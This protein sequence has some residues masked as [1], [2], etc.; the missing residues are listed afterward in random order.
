MIERKTYTIASHKRVFFCFI[1]LVL[2]AVAALQLS[3]ARAQEEFVPAPAK[4]LTSFSF[5]QFTGGVVLIRGCVAGYP[6]SLNFILDTGSGGISLDSATCEKLGIVSQ[7]SDR[8]IRG[9]AG[10]RTVR[11]VYNQKLHLPGLDVDSL[12]F[13]VND[14]EILTSAYGEQIDGIIGYS[15]LSRYIVKIDYDSSKLHVFSKGSMKYPRG[16][17][18]LRPILSTLPIQLAKIGDA[19][20]VTSRFYFDTGA[21]L[22]L[23]LSTDFVEDSALLSKKKKPVHTQGEGLGGK[24]EMKL[25]TVKEFKLGPY[26]FKKVPTYIFDDAYNVTAYPYLGGL[27]GNDILRRFNVILNY[28]RRDI[29]LTPNS[30][31]RDQF[32]YSYTGLG[33]YKIEGEVRV[34]DIMAGSP[35]EKAGFLPGDIIMAMNNNFT[36]NVQT[37]KSLMQNVGERIKVLVLREEGPIILTLRVRSILS[38]F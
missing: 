11:F 3:T 7:P 26:R 2:I 33:I 28:E 35:A 36:K 32:D 13:H 17:F 34:V 5:R 9:I 22:C 4:L 6:D 8:T 19:R 16:G 12:N 29:Y 20:S 23:L 15:F 18:L 27:I 37:Y 31:F 25:T 21:G 30:H 10:I 1:Q 24:M 14:Y 38:R